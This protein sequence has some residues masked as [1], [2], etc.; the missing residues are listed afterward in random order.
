MI[1]P[2]LVKPA[3]LYLNLESLIAYCREVYDLPVSKITIYRAVK[4]GSLPSMKVNGRLL[5]RISDVERWIEGS[6]EKKGD[7]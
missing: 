5:F 3:R 1:T 4:S 6:S 7:A 2:A